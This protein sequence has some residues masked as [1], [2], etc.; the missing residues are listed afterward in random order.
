MNKKIIL[1]IA[2]ALILAVAVLMYFYLQEPNVHKYDEEEIS[3]ECNLDN[4]CVLIN[5]DLDY[6]SCRSY[7]C[8]IIDYSQDNYIAVNKESFEFFKMSELKFRPFD[9]ECGPAPECPSRIIND[10]FVAKCINNLCKKLPR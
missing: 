8:G 5:K 6:R 9:E 10:N 7:R 3:L 1:P 4:D 2:F